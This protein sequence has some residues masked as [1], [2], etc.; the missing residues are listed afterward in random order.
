MFGLTGQ[1]LTMGAGTLI[2]GFGHYQ[3]SEQASDAGEFN[4]KVAQNNARVIDEEIKIATQK[5]RFD[6][7]EIDRQTSMLTGRQVATM[8]ASGLAIEAGTSTA[9][10]LEDTHMQAAI[11]KGLIMADLK[12]NNWRRREQ[13]KNIISGGKMDRWYAENK[14]DASMMDA[15]SS[16][17]SGG[18][19]M[20]DRWYKGKQVGV[21]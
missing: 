7:G 19:N 18:V 21:K 4:Y 6:K 16:L 13:Q 14:A 8:A 17:L 5:A 2:K 15:A 3:Q 20:Y 10:V 12:I 1:L 9:D 11:D